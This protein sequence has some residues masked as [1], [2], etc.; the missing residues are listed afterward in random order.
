M[1][2]DTTYQAAHPKYTILLECPIISFSNRKS[3]KKAVFLWDNLKSI[4]IWVVL[5]ELRRGKYLIRYDL[6]DTTAELAL[7]QNREW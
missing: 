6:S 1:V 7:E 3:I 4:D 2:E 5:G